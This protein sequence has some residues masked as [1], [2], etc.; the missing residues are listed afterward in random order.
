MAERNTN[1]RLL[2][3]VLGG[4]ILIAA[5]LIVA[6]IVVKNNEDQSTYP[7]MHTK[8][9]LELNAE[10]AELPVEEAKLLYEDAI[11]NAATELIREQTKVE[12]GRYLM[13]HDLA[14]EGLNKLLTTDDMVLDAGYKIL[15]Y[16]A[17]R[18]YFYT[19]NNEELA[20]KYNNM[21]SEATANS[22][23]AAGG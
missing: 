6:V 3:G 13:D 14:E 16:A 2:W 5:V 18:D 7:S 15:L 21:I 10:A 20:E 12:Y 17:L 9:L 4:L 8:S 23:F 1:N 19:I 22:D 11:S